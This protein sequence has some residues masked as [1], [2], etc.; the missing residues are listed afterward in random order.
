MLRDL[1]SLTPGTGGSPLRGLA[2]ARNCGSKRVSS[3]D[4]SGGNSDAKTIAPHET[5]TLAEI[6]GA[7]VISHIWFTI[8]HDDVLYPR[9]WSSVGYWYQSEP[10]KPFPRMPD[11]AD[12]LPKLR[13]NEREF[14]DLM[15]EVAAIRQRH[16]G[17]DTL[18]HDEWM[19]TWQKW[20][21]GIEAYGS[22]QQERAIAF[23]N[24]AKAKFLSA[25][26]KLPPGR[27]A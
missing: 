22:G 26:G 12:R 23:L 11:V 25:D 14:Y 20:W 5:L 7:G 1:S 10:H 24:Q 17:T 27:R 3:Y 2:N 16:E 18:S 4:V 15:S 19:Y 6:G 13:P 9:N 8:A 21:K